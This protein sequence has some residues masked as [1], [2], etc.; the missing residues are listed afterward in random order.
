MAELTGFEWSD[1]YQLG[2]K[3][4]DDEHKVLIG[5]INKLVDALNHSHPLAELQ[6]LF[7]RLM[8]YTAQHFAD[9]EQFMEKIGYEGLR[10]H[11]HTHTNLVNR[12]KEFGADLDNNQLDNIKLVSFLKMWLKSHILGIDMKY[13]V[14]AKQQ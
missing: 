10:T 3:A 2:V 1:Q 5:H 12:M 8:S 4:M 11:R 13:A 7:G 9:E 6:T 14:F